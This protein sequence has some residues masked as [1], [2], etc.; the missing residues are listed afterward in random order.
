MK[1]DNLGMRMKENYEN[2]AK[3]FL[4]RRTPV[5]VRL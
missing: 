1:K 3:V 2:R 5:V 4:T